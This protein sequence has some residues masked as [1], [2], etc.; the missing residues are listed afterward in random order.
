MLPAVPCRVFIADDVEALRVLW[1][2]FLTDDPG[3]EVVGEAGDGEATI[4]GVRETK[5][6]VLVLDLSMPK[7]DGLQV[8]RALRDEMPDVRIVVASGFLAARLAPVALELGATSYLEKGVSATALREAV[9]AACG[10]S[11]AS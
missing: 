1:T 11:E 8:I 3:L 5:P 4:E 10:A 9:H 6:D 7:V 2:Q